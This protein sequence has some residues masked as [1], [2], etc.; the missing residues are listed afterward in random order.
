MTRIKKK[1]FSLI[2]LLAILWMSVAL[3]AGCGTRPDS[4]P[5]GA[6]QGGAGQNVTLNVYA[7]ASLTAAFQ[8]L[9]K[10][11][12]QSHPGITV[13]FNFA[14]SQ[15][16]VSQIDQGA[17]ADVF[18][19]ADTSNMEKAKT[20][21]LVES[22]RIFAKNSLVLITPKSNPVGLQKYEDLTR[23]GKVVL[24]VPDVPVGNYA[25]Q[26]LKKADQVFGA[27]FSSTVLSHVVSQET[28]VKQI[29][30]KI[31]LGEGDAAFVYGTD[32]QGSAAD[33]VQVISVPE[34]VN[35][36]AAYPIAVVKRSEHKDLAEA[37]IQ[38]ILSKEGQDILKK[39]GF[40]AAA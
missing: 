34:S 12:E 1:T 40:L 26:S 32:V 36:T 3:A 24:G 30:N 6:G 25:R 23:A 17:P 18:A 22:D 11:F 13:R 7:A 21:G 19:S 10:H 28:D 31:A 4:G 14:G 5:P 38:L 33:K 2:S 27:G 15:T 16:L 29:V 8:E 9:G 39:H 37:F 35:V 20:K